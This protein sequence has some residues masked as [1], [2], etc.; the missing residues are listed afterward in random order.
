MPASGALERLIIGLRRRD[1]ATEGLRRRGR[2]AK[3]WLTAHTG[4]ATVRMEKYVPLALDSWQLH[5]A[6]VHDGK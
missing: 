3:V 6:V 5:L 4:W 2:T 1:S